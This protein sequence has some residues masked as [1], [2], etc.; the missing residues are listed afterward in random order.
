MVWSFE[1]AC[2]WNEILHRDYL[3]RWLSLSQGDVGNPASPFFHPEVVMAWVEGM[4]GQDRV[5]PFFLMARS[6]SGGSAFLPLA[7]LKTGWKQGWVRRLRPAGDRFF[8]YHDPCF[9]NA[10]SDEMDMFWQELLPR[11][12]GLEGDWHDELDLPRIRFAHARN[13][14]NWQLSDKSPFVKLDAYA[15]FDA[16][17]RSR[18]KSLRGDARRQ[19]RRLSETGEVA[20]RVHDHDSLGEV[21]DWIP[22]LEREREAKYPGARLPSGYLARLAH[23][24][25]PNSPVHCS[26]ITLDGKSISWHIG[27]CWQGVMYWYVPIYDAAF[28]AWSPGKIHLYFAIEDAYRTGVHTFD[29]LRG[30]ETYKAGWTDSEEFRMYGT[31]RQ[32]LKPSSIARRGTAFALNKLGYARALLDRRI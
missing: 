2:D 15:D 29:F 4:G 27:F 23:G 25:S 24:M 22:E 32:A 1:W 16:Y 3:A 13:D 6:D 14:T 28:S 9:A 7:R 12:Q 26:S 18:P 19:I 5:Q 10:R 20:Y 31:R 21:L 11:L 30:Q 8:D 17:L